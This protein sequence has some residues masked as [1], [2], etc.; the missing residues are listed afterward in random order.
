MKKAIAATIRL[1]PKTAKSVSSTADC[2]LV[3]AGFSDG[4]LRK[5]KVSGLSRL[6][7]GTAKSLER[8]GPPE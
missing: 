8:K 7:A 1:M 3:G 4:G 2:T 5:V 6:Y